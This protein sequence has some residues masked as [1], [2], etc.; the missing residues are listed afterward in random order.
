MKKLVSENNIKGPIEFLFTRSS[1][2]K[3]KNNNINMSASVPKIRVETEESSRPTI[4]GKKSY[5][6]QRC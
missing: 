4:K 3:K 6:C 2:A 1:D 5:A